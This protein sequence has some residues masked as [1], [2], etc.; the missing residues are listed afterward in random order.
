M[1]TSIRVYMYSYKHMCIQITHMCLYKH[2]HRGTHMCTHTPA[3]LHPW[4]GLLA[5]E[6]APASPSPN[7]SIPQGGSQQPCSHQHHLPTL[8]PLVLFLHFHLHNTPPI[9]AGPGLH[10]PP[11]PPPPSLPLRSAIVYEVHLRIRAGV[12]GS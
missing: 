10:V 4:E 5:G 9:L 12:P 2:T 7:L 1:Y 6:A 11:P 8:Y 3:K